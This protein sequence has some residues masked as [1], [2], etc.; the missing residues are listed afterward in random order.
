MLGGCSLYHQVSLLR[1]LKHGVA[2]LL[3]PEHTLLSKKAFKLRIFIHL[4]HKYM[5]LK[6]IPNHF[7]IV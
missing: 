7:P 5:E 6:A 2:A 3:R 4:P 1:V